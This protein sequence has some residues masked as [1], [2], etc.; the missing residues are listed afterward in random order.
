MKKQSD[1]PGELLFWMQHVLLEN[2]ETIMTEGTKEWFQVAHQLRE[3]IA[4]VDLRMMEMENGTYEPEQHQYT[5]DEERTACSEFLG[6]SMEEQ[7]INTLLPSLEEE[8][9]PFQERAG[10]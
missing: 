2:G 8:K 4:T 1:L 5:D 3:A 9:T 6:I 10:L 7:E